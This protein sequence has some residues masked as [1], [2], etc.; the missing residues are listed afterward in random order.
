MESLKNQLLG[1]TLEQPKVPNFDTIDEVCA[2]GFL[3]QIPRPINKEEA[4]DFATALHGSQFKVLYDSQRMIQGLIYFSLLPQD[5]QV[6]VDFLYAVEQRKGIGS[7]L[8]NDLL[9]FARS[10]GFSKVA[11][12]VSQANEGANSFYNALGFSKVG[13]SKKSTDLNDLEFQL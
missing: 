5:N 2:R 7:F 6:H 12:E 9:D 1:Y 4:M 3:E 11:L 10:R 13:E 8:V